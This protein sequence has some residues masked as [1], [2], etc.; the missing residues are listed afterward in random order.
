MTMTT[1]TTTTTTTTTTVSVHFP[2]F[3]PFILIC[4]S[5]EPGRGR[6]TDARSKLWNA[7]FDRLQSRPHRSLG[8]QRRTSGQILRL[9]AATRISLM[10][11]IWQKN[12]VSRR[13]WALYNGDGITRQGTSLKIHLSVFLFLQIGAQRRKLLRLGRGFGKVNQRSSNAIRY[14]VMHAGEWWSTLK[15]LHHQRTMSSKSAL[16]C[17]PL[18]L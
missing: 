4:V 16:L 15:Q 12:Y 9:H 14:V 2:P 6:G 10:A 5:G 18:S 1:S 13:L 7:A 8:F 11:S 3:P 17:R